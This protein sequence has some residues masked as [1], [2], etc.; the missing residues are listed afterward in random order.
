MNLQE[1]VLNNLSDQLQHEI[2]TEILWGLLTECG[3]SR[4]NLPRFIDRQHS[5]DIKIWIEEHRTGEVHQNGSSFLFENSKD[6]T[7]F[8]L[9]WA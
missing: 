2:D 9:K 5:V 4:V 3:Y 7:M 6:A 1:Q 8:I